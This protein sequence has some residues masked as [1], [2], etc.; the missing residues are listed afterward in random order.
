[1]R[2]TVSTPEMP[3]FSYLSLFK[4]EYREEV[5]MNLK[6]SPTVRGVV[7][8]FFLNKEAR[9]DKNNYVKLT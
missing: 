3:G 6:E 8:A 9:E 2:P 1:M 5:A 7:S 4:E